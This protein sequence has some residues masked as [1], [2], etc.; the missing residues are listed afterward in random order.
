MP[1]RLPLVSLFLSGGQPGP[2]LHAATAV[3]RRVI[4]QREG[5]P[6]CVLNQYLHIDFDLKTPCPTHQASSTRAGGKRSLQMAP[7]LLVRPQ[8][9]AFHSAWTIDGVG[10][11]KARTASLFSSRESL[12]RRT[13]MSVFT[14]A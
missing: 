1:R 13:E 11:L 7:R 9:T 3:G 5:V 4:P 6:P 10:L 12:N 8:T 2:A 14:P